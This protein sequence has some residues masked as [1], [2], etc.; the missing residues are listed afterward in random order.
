MKQLKT[1]LFWTVVLLIVARLFLR[2]FLPNSYFVPDESTWSRLTSWIHSNGDSTQFEGFSRSPY[3]GSQAFVLPSVWQMRL[4]DI[5]S[6]EAVRNTSTLYGIGCILIMASMTWLQACEG[7]LFNSPV[8][9]RKLSIPIVILGI[10]GLVPSHAL[11]SILG[12]RD[13][14]AE[15]YV[16][17][18]CLTL[19][20]SWLRKSQRFIS[21][22]LCFSALLGLSASRYQV[23]WL[24]CLF[25]I[26]ISVFTLNKYSRRLE[27][28]LIGVI[29]FPLT[30]FISS[31]PS[32]IIEREIVFQKN[33]KEL[34]LEIVDDKVVNTKSDGIVLQEVDGE[35]KVVE[36]D[37]KSLSQETSK[38]DSIESA[39]SVSAESISQLVSELQT[40]SPSPNTSADSVPVLRVYEKKKLVKKSMIVENVQ[41][42]VVVLGDIA[43]ERSAKQISAAAVIEEAK[44]PFSFESKIGHLSCE[45][46][47]APYASMSFLF[48]PFFFESA[49]SQEFR[50]ASLENILWLLLVILIPIL[51]IRNKWRPI[52]H[53]LPPILFLA[54]FTPLA[55]LTEGNYGTAVRHKSVT[56]WAILILLLSVN[57]QN[58]D[59]FRRRPF[60]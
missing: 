10:Y 11:W 12:L 16:M 60:S 15:F 27:F 38:G 7:N 41:A 3:F 17:L 26:L 5:S 42:P 57:L 24:M 58:R 55:A 39:D 14:A 1:S 29:A 44:C 4:F 56:L 43:N 6:L 19:Q 53:D 40:S 36:Q 28:L 25:L 9:K 21:S 2:F 47:R 59:T 48:R 18:I 34:K 20:I 51:I 45:I 52:F 32:K 22:L 50:Y 33:G 13:S 37:S 46:Y 54:L 49:T 8:E 30:I 35:L 31:V 23:A